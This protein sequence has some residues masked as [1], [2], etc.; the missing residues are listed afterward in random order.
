MPICDCCRKH[1]DV[2]DFMDDNI[3]E[4]SICPDCYYG[5]NMIDDVLDEYDEDTD[6][7]DIDDES[8]EDEDSRAIREALGDDLGY[9]ESDE[10]FDEDEF[11]DDEDNYE[12]R[13]DMEEGDYE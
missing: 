1:F 4:S 8:Y 6:L 9:D 2:E 11:G 3:T 5:G 10:E 13:L 12:D 7:D